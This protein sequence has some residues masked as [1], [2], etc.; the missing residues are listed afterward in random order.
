MSFWVSFAYF[1]NK[2]IKFTWLLGGFIY[3]TNLHKQ[4]QYLVFCNCLVPFNI[5]T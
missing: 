3:L 4:L 5:V 1:K 2:L